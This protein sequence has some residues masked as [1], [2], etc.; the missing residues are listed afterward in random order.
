MLH[1]S[2]LELCALWHIQ[3]GENFLLQNLEPLDFYDIQTR[4]IFEKTKEVFTESG[5]FDPFLLND[6]LSLEGKPS[7]WWM[8][9]ILDAPYMGSPDQ[10][11]VN[12]KRL[13]ARRE[14]K[15]FKSKAEDHDLPQEFI[16]KGKQIEE[17]LQQRG[18]NWEYVV[19]AIENPMPC[20]S[21]GYRTF[22]SLCNGGI[23][24]GGMLVVAATPGMGK[25]T[26][27]VNIA[28]NV[29]ASGKSVHFASLE[30]ADEDIVMRFMQC[31][32]K[33]SAEQVKKHIRD[34]S[35]EKLRADLTISNPNRDISRVLAS[36]NS[37]LSADL[38]IVDY[39]GL[40]ELKSKEG[41]VQKLELI[42]NMLQSFAFDNRKPVIVVSQLNRDLEKDRGNRE[43]QLSDIRGTGAL[44]QDAHIVSFLWDETAKEISSKLVDD[45]VEDLQNGKSLTTKQRKYK[46]LIKKNR[47]GMLGE[48]ELHLDWKTMTFSEKI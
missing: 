32:W 6:K 7:L 28:K 8:E 10:V 47:Y 5:S 11:S 42:S 14:A 3:S 35:V 12:L 13:R 21:T 1:D 17:Y 41:Q 23:R 25:T 27:A 40:I 9:I 29:V 16:G 37:Y 30:M 4:L 19:D 45:T 33:E 26:L 39:F 15:E 20:L 36:L 22:D 31:F 38:F 43:P 34:M 44:A 18:N 48:V 24:A 46:W 2:K